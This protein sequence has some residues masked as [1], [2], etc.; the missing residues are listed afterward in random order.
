MTSR[1][2]IPPDVCRELKP[3]AEIELARRNFW[4]F[5]RHIRTNDNETEMI[6]AFPA[7]PYLRETKEFF[8]TYPVTA[9]LKSR[10]LMITTLI[11][12]DML[13]Q[14]WKCESKNNET[15]SGAI[16]S[17]GERES[18][19]VM[20][21]AQF[22]HG[23][24]PDVFSEY[25]PIKITKSTIEF[26]NGGSIMSLP[27]SEDIGRTF[28]FTDVLLDE[29]AFLPFDRA[30]WRSLRPTARKL[31]CVSTP[32]GKA[33]LFAQ[34]W[35]DHDKYQIGRKTLHWSLRPDR[36]AWIAEMKASMPEADYLR[37]YELSFEVLAGERVY[38]DFSMQMH[39]TPIH[40]TP[41]SSLVVYRGW[42]FGYH[43]PA[44]I[45]QIKNSRDQLCCVMEYQ[46]EAID[47]YELC[48]KVDEMSQA[49]FPRCQFIDWCDPAGMQMQSAAKSERS[50]VEVLKSFG[51]YPRAKARRI[52]EGVDI[53][54]QLLRM[55]K[56]GNPGLL[57]DPSCEML[58]AAYMGGYHYP[59]QKPNRAKDEN[60]EKDG[61]Y[62]HI[63]DAH[64]YAVTGITE[65]MQLIIRGKPSVKDVTDEERFQYIDPVIGV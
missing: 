12:L 49:K 31:R 4:E 41:H 42:D 2:D 23:T 61:T 50:D 24:L 6:H 19:E 5:A 37:E 59:E 27:A 20:D 35:F 39:V 64:R 3:W 30:M 26:N 56:D 1:L 25:N 60:P 18:F 10:R 46:G 13:W 9:I 28:G 32:N 65:N 40:F 17:R 36:E 44:V 48:R 11:A 43:S 38:P 7:W 47:T 8:D 14:A 21:R 62:D 53:I 52:K 15:Y 34:L 55:R 51:I 22:M 63:A 33:N 29:M 54:R 45:W 16:V 58:I 57:V